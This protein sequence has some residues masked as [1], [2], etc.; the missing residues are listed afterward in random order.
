MDP[1]ALTTFL[2][3]WGYSAF[4]V[5]LGIT[6]FGFPIPEDLL[7]LSGGYLI[8]LGVF[9]WPIAL[10]LAIAGVVTSDFILFTFG[11]RVRNHS[12]TGRLGR[13]V[14]VT[15]L[16]RFASWF[17][18]VGAAAVFIARLVPGTRAVVFVSAGLR[19]VQPA[20]FLAYDIAGALIWASALVW[21]GSLL[22]EHI[23]DLASLM[24]GIARTAFWV[25]VAAILLLTLWRFWRAEESKL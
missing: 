12:G 13:F 11:R 3:N 10:P 18:R 20:V 25:I 21:L 4:F 1:A 24:D 7:L 15:R 22:G 17:D 16:R 8:S 5:M 2:E 14:P 6:A 19:G 9:T 23:G